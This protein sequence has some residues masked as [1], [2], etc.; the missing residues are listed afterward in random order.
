MT[1][2]LRYPLAWPGGW[3]RTP[4]VLRRRTQFKNG[5]YEIQLGAAIDRLDHQLRLL[6]S[7]GSFV[8]STNQPLT[9]SGWPRAD[10]A[11]PSDPGAA[12]Y[13]KLSG[14]DR[15]L[16]CDSYTSVAGNVA[17]LAAH[18]EALR[19][20]DRYG[21]G[22]LDQAFTGYTALPPSEE[23]WWLVLGVPRTA[24]LDDVER[25][26]REKAGAAHPD[27]EGGNH[28]DM[29]RLNAAREAARRELRQTVGV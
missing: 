3:K 4:H 22:T 8:L 7:G 6:T 28:N 27:R 2:D 5:K 1:Q 26:F 25:V 20:I 21:V 23:E 14:K 12:V 16:G 29:A 15:C 18:I 19:A 13:F 9:K 11:E 10:R 24:S 17:A